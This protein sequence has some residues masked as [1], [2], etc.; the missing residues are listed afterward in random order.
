[1]VGWLEYRIEPVTLHSGGK[2]HWLVRGDLIF[3]DKCLREAVLTHWEVYVRQTR[4]PYHFISI[5]TG[6]DCW[7][8]A[9]AARTGGE[10]SILHAVRHVRNQATE[11]AVDDVMTTGGSLRAA[12]G[13]MRLVVVDRMQREMFVPN[14]VA[15]ATMYLPLLR[16]NEMADPIMLG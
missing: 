12:P 10:W 2:S 14:V 8:E 4:R 11:F 9:I 7:A 16:R 6:G 3:E 5:P 15:W 1:M 13:K